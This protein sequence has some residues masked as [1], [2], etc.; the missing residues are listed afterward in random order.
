MQSAD[1][2]Q[3]TAAQLERY[4]LILGPGPGPQQSLDFEAPAYP[5]GHRLKNCRLGAFTYFNAA[6]Q[7]SAYRVQ[8]GR[9]SQIGESSIIGPPEH[10]QDWFSNHPFA[11]TR[12]SLMPAIYR[13]QEFRRLGPDESEGPSYVNTVVNETF[14]GHEAYIG[15]GC[16]VRRGVRI[17]NG[18]VIGARSVV[19]KEV[20]PYTVVAGAPARVVKMRHTEKVVERF[21][22]LEWWKYDLAPFK[23][24]VDFSKVEATLDFFEQKLAD[25]LLKPFEPKTYRLTAHGAARRL[26]RL[27]APMRFA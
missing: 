21:L 20:A 14:V 22:K 25:G 7:T 24:D 10:P 11:F 23:N 26:E 9:Y 17:G 4:G 13:T 8:F 16:F 15:V 3:L 1:T 27:P 5:F 12:P 18:A 6:G 19:T 2:E